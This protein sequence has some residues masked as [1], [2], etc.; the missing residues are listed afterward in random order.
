M[1]LSKKQ[2]VKYTRKL[3]RFLEQNHDIRF[4]KLRLYQG[5]ITLPT[6]QTNHEVDGT[7]F[8]TKIE[9]DPRDTVISTLIHEFIHYVHPDWTEEKVLLM[10]KTLMNKLTDRQIKN[11]IKKLATVL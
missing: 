3:Y 1:E 10:E 9:L 6:D 11:I 7:L 4:K 2:V 5:T 8:I